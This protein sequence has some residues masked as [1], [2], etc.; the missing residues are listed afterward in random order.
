VAEQL[1]RDQTLP[2]L[3]RIALPALQATKP[4]S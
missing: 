3:E 1:V 4:R 2:D